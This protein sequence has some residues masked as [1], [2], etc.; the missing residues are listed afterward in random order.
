MEKKLILF[1]IFIIINISFSNQIFEFE[2]T[3]DI[4]VDSDSESESDEFY[5]NT[6][7][8]ESPCTRW[9]PSLF[10]P[11]LLIPK[12]NI[13]AKGTSL[14][15]INFYI[16]IPFIDRNNDIKILPFEGVPS[17]IENY[18]DILMKSFGSEVSL[19]YFGISP[20]INIYKELNKEHN[21]LNNLKTKE[22]IKE[23]IFSFTKW[24]IKAN[25]PKSKLYLGESQNIFKSNEGIIGTCESYPNDSLWGCS[26]KEMILNNISI[27]LKNENQTLYKI[28]FASEIQN[29]YFPK[30]Y[31]TIFKELSKDS[32][33]INKKN[34]LECRNFF[35]SSNYVSLQ[36]TEE[37]EKF[38]I[39]GQVDNL[40]R[41]NNTDA[42]SKKDMARIR[43]EDIRYIILPIMT[44]KEF[45]VQFDAENS[46]ISFYTNNSEILKVKE[47]EKNKSSSIGSILIIILIILLILGLSYGIYWFFIKKR[48][49][50]ET[51]INTFSKF[52]DEEDYKNL[53]EKKVFKRVLNN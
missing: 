22:K 53:N 36:L 40:A 7:I 48:R 26:F 52:E 44:F 38:I 9:T 2:M 39:K 3:L 20:G 6:Q 35:N 18:E 42:E 12:K 16:N 13:I 10:I 24:D 4:D 47:K 32:C 50:I 49:N 8:K 14:D 30:S 46:L 45:H 17:I 25:P 29:L 11:T 51:N 37:N 19:C 34:Y 5:I 27:P 21:T 33:V 41:F 43:F 23:R 31:E 1:L 28:Y 15:G